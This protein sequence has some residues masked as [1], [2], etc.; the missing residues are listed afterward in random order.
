[1]VLLTSKCPITQIKIRSIR[2]PLNRTQDTWMGEIRRRYFGCS[3]SYKRAWVLHT[4]ELVFRC[5]WNRIELHFTE[6]SNENWFRAFTQKAINFLS[7]CRRFKFQ[8]MV[9]QCSEGSAQKHTYKSNFEYRP[10]WTIS[11]VC[12]VARHNQRIVLQMLTHHSVFL[13]VSSIV[14]RRRWICA[15]ALSKTSSTT[16]LGCS[17]CI[18]IIIF[19]LDSTTSLASNTHTQSIRST[20]SSRIVIVIS[21]KWNLLQNDIGLV[22]R[23]YA[24]LLSRALFS[25]FP[26]YYIT[27]HGKEWKEKTGK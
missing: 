26:E 13:F 12:G 21:S 25:P 7:C 19:H 3:F 5:I 9:R 24:I 6:P 4:N 20:C 8:L 2:E 11:T 14:R 27:Q 1:M 17:V 23:L 18:I 16:T 15:F 22:N 10:A